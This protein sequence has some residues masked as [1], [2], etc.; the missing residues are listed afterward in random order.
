[1]A[2]VPLLRRACRHASYIS[3]HELVA[4]AR[5]PIS[6]FGDIR[7]CALADF[8]DATGRAS[9]TFRMRADFICGRSAGECLRAMMPL[10]AR[11]FT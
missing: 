8:L 3:R 4:K 2:T 6:C 11:A 7:C 10:Y 1:M 5:F 9:R